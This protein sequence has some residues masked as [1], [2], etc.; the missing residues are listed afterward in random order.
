MGEPLSSVEDVRLMI[1]RGTSG[2]KFIYPKGPFKPLGGKLN[3]DGVATFGLSSSY[4]IVWFMHMC[5]LS[6]RAAVLISSNA[7]LD[8]MLTLVTP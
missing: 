2:N 4:P 1:Y 8:I 7:L 3:K 6:T 5:C